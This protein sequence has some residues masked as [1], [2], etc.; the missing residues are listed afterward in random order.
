MD[1][2]QDALVFPDDYDEDE[3]TAEIDLYFIALF[4]QIER[5]NS[6][7]ATPTA[8]QLQEFNTHEAILQRFIH[9]L[10]VHSQRILETFKSQVGYVGSMET[11]VANKRILEE[12]RL[13]RNFYTDKASKPNNE[14]QPGT[15]DP[16]IKI[17]HKKH[18]DKEQFHTE[19]KEHACHEQLGIDSQEH[20]CKERPVMEHKELHTERKEHER[21]EQPGIESQEHECKEPPAMERKTHII[22]TERNE[23]TDELTERKEHTELFERNEQLEL[24][25]RKEH[26]E[27][28]ERNEQLELTERKEHTEPFERNEQLELTERNEQL[29]L[30]ERNEHTDELTERKEHTEPFERNEQLELTERKEHSKHIE[31]QEHSDTISHQEHTMIGLERMR[32][33]IDTESSSCTTWDSLDIDNVKSMLDI[34]F[35]LQLVD[36]TETEINTHLMR[37]LDIATVKSL[38]AYNPE[39]QIEMKFNIEINTILPC[40][41][42]SILSRP[43]LRVKSNYLYV[44]NSNSKSTLTFSVHLGLMPWSKSSHKKL[45]RSFE[46]RWRPGCLTSALVT[47]KPISTRP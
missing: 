43:Y 47:A 16:E 11:F 9:Q 36:L 29:E 13:D 1:D 39:L 4:K 21:H 23:H 8:E 46:R 7:Y 33:R 24:T 18:T 40:E 3:L 38:L 2:H 27:P 10:N 19:R 25:E 31:R 30:T 37:G 44:W 5:Q 22:L 45:Y 20:E 17:E 34:E 14:M 41:P 32:T 12:V 15:T 28:F 35:K 26:T 6:Y 42:S